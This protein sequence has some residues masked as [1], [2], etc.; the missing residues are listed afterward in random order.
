M[1]PRLTTTRDRKQ[2]VMIVPRNR[3]IW[4]VGMVLVPAAILSAAAPQ[5]APLCIA[6]AAALAAAAVGDALL[7]GRRTRGLKAGWGEPVRLAKDRRGAVPLRI[8]NAAGVARRVRLG[9]AWPEE[10]VPDEEEL[11]VALP[12]GAERSRVDWPVTPRRRGRYVMDRVWLEAA[13][14][15]GLWAARRAVEA[16][17]EVRVYPN[18]VT[19]RKTL[20]A[21]LLRSGQIG[22]HAQRQLGKG[23]EFEKLREYIPG[24]GFEDIHW[25]ATAKRGKPITKVFQIERT[26]EVYVVVD[27]SRL[28]ARS[29]EA[30]G[31]APSADGSTVTVL[32]RYLTAGLVLALAAEK[33]GDLFGFLTF[34]D[35]VDTF[36]PARTGRTHYGACR[37]AL[38]TTFPRIVTPDY[39]ELASFIRLRLRRRAL[40]V[41][42]TSLEDPVLA[43][44]FARGME[45]ISGRHLL[46]VNVP[47]APLVAPLFGEADVAAPEDLY[48]RL[49][50]HL[51]HEQLLEL[52]RKLRRRGIGFH[53]LNN[54]A[55]AAELVNQYMNVK[56]RQ[57]L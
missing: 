27:A 50:G 29:A 19:E 1:S 25:K 5:A 36:V 35:K 20:S 41:V 40:L 56:R 45:L 37:D 32:E 4:L 17:V 22:V 26:Q 8:E 16:N 13:S 55:M 6:T 15:L 54:D 10:L 14:P 47:S 42:L 21:L 49:G 18:L 52:E 33:H 53:R 24:D 3:L 2:S 30:V 51:R 7:A 43:E 38:Y 28:S 46:L 34:S 31:Q 57:M 23:R 39:D 48:R 12:A 11:D 44:S 9:L